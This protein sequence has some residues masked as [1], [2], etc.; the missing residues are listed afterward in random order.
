MPSYRRRPVSR[1]FQRWQLHR[2]ISSLRMPCNCGSRAHFATA[3]NSPCGL[4]QFGCLML[5]FAKSHNVSGIFAQVCPGAT[6]DW[7]VRLTDE[8]VIAG[9]QIFNSQ[10]VQIKMCLGLF[11]FIDNSFTNKGAMIG[12]FRN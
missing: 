9:K 4:K 8:K 2:G 1:I 7:L 6:A 10:S 5:H 12:S 11:A 3:E